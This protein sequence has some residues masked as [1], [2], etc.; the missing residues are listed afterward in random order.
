MCRDYVDVYFP[1]CNNIALCNQKEFMTDKER[2]QE[3]GE[4]VAALCGAFSDLPTYEVGYCLIA[5]A[6]M[7]MLDTAPNHLI[8]MKTIMTSVEV[9]IDEYQQEK[10]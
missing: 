6:T 10:G 4:D 7:L 1:M 5:Y 3:L 9:G 8:A 2:V